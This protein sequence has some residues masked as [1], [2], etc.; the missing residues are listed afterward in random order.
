MAMKTTRILLAD[1]SGTVCEAA[2]RLR[3][4]LPSLSTGACA[5]RSA[6]NTEPLTSWHPDLVLLDPDLDE[7]GG[8]V[9]EPGT[10]TSPGASRVLVLTFS[11]EQAKLEQSHQD[12]SMCPASR[13]QRHPEWHLASATIQSVEMINPVLSRYDRKRSRSYS[14]VL[15]EL[16]HRAGSSRADSFRPRDS[17]GP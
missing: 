15:G 14:P 16:F 10:K 5:V 17:V 7:S 13:P 9:P 2:L 6:D 4:V 1:K 11:Y 3:R 12:R 8:A